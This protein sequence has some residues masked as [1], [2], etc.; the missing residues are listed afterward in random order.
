MPGLALRPPL[1]SV[2]LRVSI[3][4]SALDLSSHTSAVLATFS[5][6]RFLDGLWLVFSRLCRVP[7]RDLASGR[8]VPSCTWFAFL[9][10]FVHAFWTFFRM[11]SVV[12]CWS[13]PLCVGLRAGSSS[14]F[15]FPGATLYGPRALFWLPPLPG[16]CFRF[17]AVHFLR[18]ELAFPSSGFP[19]ALSFFPLWLYGPGPLRFVVFCQFSRPFR[20]FHLV[21]LCSLPFFFGL[22][23]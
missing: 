10:S 19:A 9:S 11:T 8:A 23:C 16:S 17:P 2:R 5:N 14:A 20:P 3:H 18:S 12:V 21:V 22:L 15:P 13:A 4:L 7:L 6:L 1:P